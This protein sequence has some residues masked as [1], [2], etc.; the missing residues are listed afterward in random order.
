MQDTFITSH[1][2]SYDA[3]VLVLITA[4]AALLRHRIT[5]RKYVPPFKL[6]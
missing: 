1:Q 6:F 4:T 5:L 3:F 2:F